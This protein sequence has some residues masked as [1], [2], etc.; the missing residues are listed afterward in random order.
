MQV[1]DDSRVKSGERRGDQSVATEELAASAGK[2]DAIATKT[3]LRTELSRMIADLNE[4]RMRL[5]AVV[6]KFAE[7][8]SDPYVDQGSDGER[9]RAEVS[10]RVEELRVEL[11]R[12]LDRI[13]QKLVSRMPEDS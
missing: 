6:R 4:V 10:E 12:Q 11:A 13:R 5:D 1:E 8:P 7:P 9:G 3:E 2:D